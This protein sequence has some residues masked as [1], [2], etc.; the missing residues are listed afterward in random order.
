VEDFALQLA[1][2]YGHVKVV[3]ELLAHGADVH[4]LDGYA[5]ICL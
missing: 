1:S 4:A 5:L 3:K 2:N